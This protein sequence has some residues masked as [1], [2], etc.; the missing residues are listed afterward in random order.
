MRSKTGVLALALSLAA[1]LSSPALADPAAFDAHAAATATAF[2]TLATFNAIQKA[3]EARFRVEQGQ[4]LTL[5][6]QVKTGAATPAQLAQAEQ[7]LMDQ[8]AA[9]SVP[10]ADKTAV[11]RDAALAIASSPG[12]AAALTQFNNG[13]QAGALLAL[14]QLQAADAASHPQRADAETA[15]GER[16]IAALALEAMAKGKADPASVIARYEHVT[17]L[18]P[19]NAW[20]W[21]VLEHLYLDDTRPTDAWQAVQKAAKAAHGDRERAMTQIELGAMLAQRRDVA[22]A[23][24]AEQQALDIYRREA[25][26]DPANVGL[27]H[28]ISDVLNTNTGL[29]AAQGDHDGALKSE[30]ESLDIL[31]R[32]A[33]ADPANGGLQRDLYKRLWSLAKAQTPLAHWSDVVAQLTLMDQN[34]VLRPTD[35]PYLAEARNRAAAA[36]P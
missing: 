10:Y 23:S 22:G 11:L 5:A 8:L 12:G 33:A 2:D 31:R 26:A 21:V 35:Q 19:S 20:D 17:K 6:A 36:A 27:Q 7:T 24:A 4:I 1:G 25:A 13:D 32:L 28:A 34:G 15:E 14:D 29:L 16:R 3:D 9:Q 30:S 18:D